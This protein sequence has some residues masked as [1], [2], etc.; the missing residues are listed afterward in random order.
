M[1]SLLGTCLLAVLVT[2][3]ALMAQS[4]FDGTW[5]VDLNSAMPTKTNVWLLQNG[6]YKCTSCVPM[7]DV[8]ADGQDQQVTGQPYDTIS[9]KIIDHLTVEE[10]EKKNGQIV[11]DE[12]FTVSPDGNTAADEFA[13][14]KIRMVRV[15]KAPPESHALSGSWKPSKMES[16][17][18]KE[19]LIAYK[20]DGD[21]LSMSRPTGESY[22]ARLDGTDAPYKGDPDTNTVSIKR[23]DKSTIE[24]TDKLNGKVLSVT[25]MTLALDGKSMTVSS[26]DA[27][28]GTTNQVT[29]RKE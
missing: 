23:I 29:M 19:P 27:Q 26:K 18:D 14:W 4:G 8:K 13:N 28:D 11:S 12:K 17:S 15:A 2:P 21:T 5:K 7:I 6:T 16:I 20:I 1:K 24:E 3:V 10:V 9:V 25:R 22:T